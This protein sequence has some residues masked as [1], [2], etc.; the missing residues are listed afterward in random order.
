[1]RDEDVT[2]VARW[3]ADTEVLGSYGGRTD[4]WDESRVRTEMLL[5]A[6]ITPCII[7]WGGEEI[8]YAQIYELDDAD[9]EEYGYAR[10]LRVFGM[11]QFIGERHLWNS[12]VGSRLVRALCDYLL[13][14]HGADVVT[15]DPLTTNARA[16]RAYE[17]AG[18][19]TI[20]ILPV[21]ERH[22]GKRLD[23]FLMEYRASSP[24]T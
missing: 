22:D 24:G 3:L 12:G 15:L 16:I 11:D 21:H 4:P 20:K 7:I 23:C 17:K 13:G 5:E 14:E 18:F 9:Y 8:G 1:M 2:T 6:S 10:S 19:R